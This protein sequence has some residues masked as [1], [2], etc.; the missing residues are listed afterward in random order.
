MDWHWQWG[1]E[2]SVYCDARYKAGER[3]ATAVLCLHECSL[4]AVALG[5]LLSDVEDT[6]CG[7]CIIILFFCKQFNSWI[8]TILLSGRGKTLVNHSKKNRQGEV[9]AKL[10]KQ[11][12]TS[13]GAWQI[14]KTR[15]R[16][17]LG[18]G[19]LVKQFIAYDSTVTKITHM[20]WHAENRLEW[21]R[22]K[23]KGLNY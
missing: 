8:R 13:V 9:F 5:I 20:I 18:G 22:K 1:E 16:S 19:G 12:T 7:A 10:K 11:H 6:L 15:E 21:V 14:R 17:D 23:M 2:L 3:Q 4:V